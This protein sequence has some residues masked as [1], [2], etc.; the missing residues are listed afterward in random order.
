M[1]VAFLANQFLDPRKPSSWS[2]VPYFTRRALEE[3]G[4]ETRLVSC[5]KSHRLEYWSRFFYWKLLHK[6]RY[7]RH[8]NEALLR[9]Y[10]RQ[11]SR[12]LTEGPPVDAVF[13]VST[14]LVAYLKTDLP[15]LLHTDACFGAL[16]GFYE[17]FSNLAATSIR[18]GHQVEHLALK[19]CTRIAYSSH[20][21]AR[22]AQEIYHVD[23]AKIEV[24]NYGAGFQEPPDPARIASAIH[25]RD[26]SVCEILLVGVDWVRKGADLAVRTAEA[27]QALGCNVRLTIVGCT[28]PKKR[29]LPRCVE[30]IPFLDKASPEGRRRL[31]EIYLRSHFFIL[32]SR[33]EASAVV[34]SEAAAYGLPSLAPDVGGQSSIVI[35]NVNG[36][37]FSLAED[38]RVYATYLFDLIKSPAR[39]RA[40]A[41]RSLEEFT[42]RLSW[43][44]SGG[45]LATIL[46]E[47]AGP[48]RSDLL[49]GKLIVQA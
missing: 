37:L 3:A 22:A 6:K 20:W 1:R 33:A 14:W 45:K 12:K 18:E 7:L 27:L 49:A 19:R 29:Q 28:P 8:C 34:F 35:N 11:L 21:A 48:Q 38:G 46:D 26:L 47:I 31:N 44:V 23:S 10:G 17:S 36:R 41:L 25:A 4:V 42:S 5:G 40:L 24:V 43:K 32:P 13:S 2:G 39:Y 16:L 30:V 15:V 9:S